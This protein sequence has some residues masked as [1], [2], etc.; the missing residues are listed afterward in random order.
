MLIYKYLIIISNY[1]LSRFPLGEKLKFSAPSPV[2]EGWEG[3]K[4]QLN[5]LSNYS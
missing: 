4:K 5:L 2:G 3:G 1:P